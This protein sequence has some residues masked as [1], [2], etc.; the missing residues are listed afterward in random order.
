MEI[1]EL[2]GGVNQSYETGTRPWH[3][4]QNDLTELA[5]YAVKHPEQVKVIIDNIRDMN[6]KTRFTEALGKIDPR[7]PRFL[8]C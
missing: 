2:I 6:I 5:K 4:V 8:S 3:T 7:R 1:Q